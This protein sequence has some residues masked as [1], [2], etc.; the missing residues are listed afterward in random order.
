MMELEIHQTTIHKLHHT[1][2]IPFYLPLGKRTT[3]YSGTI[4]YTCF[5]FGTA[6]R[7]SIVYK[8]DELHLYHTKKNLQ[9]NY[10]LFVCRP[11]AFSLLKRDSEFGN[12]QFVRGNSKGPTL[13][14]TQ[15][16][17]RH[18][19][20]KDHTH[21]HKCPKQGFCLFVGTVTKCSVIIVHLLIEVASHR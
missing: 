4:K 14:M 21:T 11:H 18:L 12:R 15:C 17:P 5:S 6:F 16:R 20:I 1:P 9:N 7:S 10:F 8:F 3:V 19:N 13:F 2:F